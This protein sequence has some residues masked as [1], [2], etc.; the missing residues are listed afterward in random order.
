M[1]KNASTEVASDDTYI[2]PKHGWTCFHCGETFRTVDA[3]RD[4]FGATPQQ[5]PGCMERVR[6]GPER[7]LLTALREAE[8]KIAWYMTHEGDAHLAMTELQARHT[9]QLRLAEEVGYQR[10]LRREAREWPTIESAP[11]DGT[12]II[13][14]NGVSL[15]TGHFLKWSRNPDG[16]VIGLEEEDHDLLVDQWYWSFEMFEI[17]PPPTHWQPLPEPPK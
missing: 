9:G 2:A 11:K 3:A 17:K 12:T 10:G 14:W 15:G 13:L 4:H 5:R 1:T 7:G 8:K 6:L 16:T